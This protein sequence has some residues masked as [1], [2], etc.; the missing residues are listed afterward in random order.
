MDGGC[1]S[2]RVVTP[3]LTGRHKTKS[4]LFGDAWIAKSDPPAQLMKGLNVSLNP[5][6]VYKF[7]K[8]PCNDSGKCLVRAGCSLLINRPY[9]RKDKCPLYKR[10]DQLDWKIYHLWVW[11]INIT[12]SII[13]CLIVLYIVY[14][15]G[16]GL[17]TEFKIVKGWF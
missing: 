4:R 17:V 11:M 8:D 14:T 9:L 10:Y 3:R 2:E 5:K 15:F 12:G 1:Y 13:C 7:L 6:I 16:L